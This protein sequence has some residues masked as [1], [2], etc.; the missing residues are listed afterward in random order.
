MG[1]KSVQKAGKVGNKVG[2][3]S[4]HKGLKKGR[5][6]LK[7]TTFSPYENMVGV[8]KVRYSRLR[9]RNRASIVH[10]KM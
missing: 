8:L 7:K 2:L 5:T 3:L 10:V 4:N 6:A 9:S 1:V